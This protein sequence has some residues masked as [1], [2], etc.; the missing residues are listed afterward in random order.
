MGTVTQLDI[1]CTTILVPYLLS[2]VVITHF[3]GLAQER[4]N[5]IANALELRLS[6]SNLWIW[7]LGTLRLN[8]WMPNLQMR[9][10]DLI[11][12]QDSSPSN[13]FQMKNFTFKPDL[14]KSL[15]LNTDQDKFISDN[16]KS[17]SMHQNIWILTSNSYVISFSSGILW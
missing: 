14:Q 11:T 15:F 16:S 4:C 3:D 12:W 7:R 17:I 2:Q 9:C 13:L 5:S 6:C 1:S 8:S 10:T